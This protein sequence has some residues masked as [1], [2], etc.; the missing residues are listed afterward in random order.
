MFDFLV[1]RYRKCLIVV[2]F[3]LMGIPSFLLHKGNFH[4]SYI[5][6][7]VFSV[8]I[9][10]VCDSRKPVI[11]S[12]L[13]RRVYCTVLFMFTYSLFVVADVWSELENFLLAF[14]DHT[15]VLLSWHLLVCVYCFFLF[16]QG[17]EGV[18]QRN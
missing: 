4:W 2:G 17:E 13:G 15:F 11:E 6:L 8:G 9:L 5:V 7:Y 16:V 18:S 3:L 12:D 1:L 10:S 14:F